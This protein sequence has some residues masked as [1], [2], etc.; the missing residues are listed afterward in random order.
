MVAFESKR[1]KV[2]RAN[3]PSNRSTM[4]QEKQI[5]HTKRK[6]SLRSFC[7]VSGLLLS[8]VCCIALVHVEFRIQEHHRLL[9]HSTT[10][11]DQ[12][13]EKILRKVQKNFK[14][15]AAEADEKL[16]GGKGKLSL[17]TIYLFCPFAETRA[18]RLVVECF[19]VR[20]LFI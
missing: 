2:S 8:I 3:S 18:V 20:I 15:W 9:S 7:A 17:D 6:K 11:C 1:D 14:R 16:S 4:N 12:I 10:F 13:E 5:P 19:R